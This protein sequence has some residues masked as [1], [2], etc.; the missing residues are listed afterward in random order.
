MRAQPLQAVRGH[1]RA[2]LEVALAAPVVVRPAEA[3]AVA[4]AG[5]LEHALGRRDDLVADAVA[6]DHRDVVDDLVHGGASFR[7]SASGGPLAPDR[8]A[9]VES[10][11]HAAAHPRPRGDEP[12]AVLRPARGRRA[13][14]PR[15]GDVLPPPVGRVPRRV[16]APRARGVPHA[17]AA[18]ARGRLP[19]PAGEHALG[20]LPG[21]R[22]RGR[23]PVHDALL[24]PAAGER[25]RVVRPGPR[26]DARGGV[27]ARAPR[28]PARRGAGRPAGD[29]RR[30]PRPLRLHVR[31][32]APD[33]LAAAELRAEAMDVSDAWVAAGCDVDD[34]RLAQER[35]LL[36]RSYAALLAAV[37]R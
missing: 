5:R 1:H 18:D 6:G 32:G 33:V 37:H 12:D 27:V 4:G 35:A 7:V 2:G 25:G 19:R 34:P 24:P 28:E 21:Q 16:R 22:S 14:D 13:R 36:V 3:E 20:A 17:V 30:A 29:R 9:P 10:R 8:R 11:H 23:P 15:V 26:G 31:R